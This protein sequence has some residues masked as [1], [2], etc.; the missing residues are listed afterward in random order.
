MASI[1]KRFPV[2]EKNLLKIFLSNKYINLQVVNNRTGHI[3][4]SASTMEKELKTKL[5]NT[6]DRA[7]AA[8]TAGVLARRARDLG[9]QQL[10]YERGKQ[11]FEGKVKVI[12]NTLKN[13]GIEFVQ[14]ATKRP[15]RYP[16]ET[17]PS[18]SGS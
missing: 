14:H 16:W 6:A 1:W 2:A 3:F 7:A 15:V 18:G 17:P 10:T 13:H 4:L 5:T 9:Q 11:R 8:A 12:V